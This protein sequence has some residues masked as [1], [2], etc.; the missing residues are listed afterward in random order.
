LAIV[1]CHIFE[2][3]DKVV[4]TSRHITG[5]VMWSKPWGPTSNGF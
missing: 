3:E 4:I 2:H 5:V 1:S